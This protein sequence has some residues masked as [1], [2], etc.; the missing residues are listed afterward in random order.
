MEKP[1]YPRIKLNSNDIL[2]TNP[3]LQRIPEVKLQHN[4]RPYPKEK[5]DVNHPTTNPK[6]ENYMYIMIL[7]ISIAR[8]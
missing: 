8:I 1:K 2:F 6:G 7:I 3:S 4:V 5:Q